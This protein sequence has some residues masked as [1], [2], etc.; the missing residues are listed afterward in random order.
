LAEQRS[1]SMPPKMGMVN[2]RIGRIPQAT[3]MHDQY[4]KNELRRLAETDFSHKFDDLISLARGS[5]VAFYPIAVP[6]LVPALPIP[7][8]MPLRPDTPMQ[9]VRVDGGL[10]MLAAGTDG[11]M[12]PADGSL[13]HGLQRM[14]QDITAHYLLGYYSTNS[15][16]DGKIRM[17]KVR[18]KK[19]GSVVRARPFYRAPSNKEMKA[20]AAP[21]KPGA[22]PIVAPPHVVA[23]L[24]VL[25]HS[26]P[27]AQFNAYAALAGPTLTVVVEVPPA[28][29][30]AGRWSD[31]ASLEVIADADNGDTAAMGRGRL[32][33]NGRA[34]LRIPVTGPQQPSKVMVRLRATGESLV[35]R[36][37][38]PAEAGKLIG[39]P[40]G[41]RSGP[42]GLATPVGIFE[43]ARDEKVRLDW[44]LLGKVESAEARLLDRRGEP[45]KHRINA[46]L[47]QSAEG[48]QAVTEIAFNPLGRGDYVVELSATAG[49]ATERRVLA[50]RVK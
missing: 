33:A 50:F 1:L 12:M 27:S 29:V 21:A 49:G 11:L 22:A 48:G 15:K 5:N 36:L 34:L 7:R 25:S 3:D 37:T 8:G 4:C 23:A 10:G 42:R 6:M 18:L 44:P 31:G 28:A 17:I 41:Y 13:G 24:D 14:M 2:G 45:L 20:M 19:D 47:Q 38:L 9:R 40:L 35:E 32:P 30:D 16:A 46:T 43:F 39:D 26:R